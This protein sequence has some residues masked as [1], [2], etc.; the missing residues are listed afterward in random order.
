VEVP[1]NLVSYRGAIRGNNNFTLIKHWI[2][3][4]R[5][6]GIWPTDSATQFLDKHRDNND[7]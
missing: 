2:S 7:T 1:K 5:L 6:L 4:Y 3:I